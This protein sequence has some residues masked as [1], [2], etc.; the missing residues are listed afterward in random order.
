M[1]RQLEVILLLY[2]EGLVN[3]TEQ[4]KINRVS[5]RQKHEIIEIVIYNFFLQVR[6]EFFLNL[7]VIEAF[8]C[9]Y[10]EDR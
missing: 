4:H 9:G 2:Y 3:R 10:F 1:A 6:M 8:V 5:K 7:P